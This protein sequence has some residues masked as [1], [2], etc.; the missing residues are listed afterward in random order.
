M[1]N[2]LLAMAPQLSP[3]AAVRFCA[4]G[5]ARLQ[6][7]AKFLFESVHARVVL[8]CSALMGFGD[9]PK[10]LSVCPSRYLFA[11]SFTA[12]FPSPRRSYT[13]PVRYDRS[14]QLRS[15]VWGKLML[16]FARPTSAGPAPTDCAGKLVLNQSYRSAPVTVARFSL[17]VSCANAPK[18]WSSFCSVV[19]GAAYS[20]KLVGAP[21][22]KV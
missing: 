7:T 10:P 5:L 11:A 4:A 8:F 6:S 19:N 1:P 15:S 2:A 21:L 18:S 16:R 14:F 9:V 12:D 20:V 17:H 3:P 13:M 22:R